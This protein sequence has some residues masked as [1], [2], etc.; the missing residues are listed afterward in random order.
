VIR[1][2]VEQLAPLVTLVMQD[3]ME[4]QAHQ[5]LKETKEK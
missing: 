3:L 5:E 4:Q 2:S 1:G